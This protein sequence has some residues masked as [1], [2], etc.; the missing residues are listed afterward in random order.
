M[1]IRVMYRNRKYDL[2]KD[3][4][5]QNLISSG[6]VNRFYRADGW[7]EIGRDPLRGSGTHAYTGPERREPVFNRPL[8]SLI[9]ID[10]NHYRPYFS[11]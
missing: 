7:A 10:G 5:L 3:F 6:R 4:F 9:H 2:V 11:D 1:L 8:D